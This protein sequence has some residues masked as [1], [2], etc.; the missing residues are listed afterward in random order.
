MDKIILGLLMLNRLTVY[1]IRG[2]I[3]KNFQAM[4]SDS[5][6]S[7]Q[8]AMKKLLSAQMVTCSEYIE[9]SVNKKR[10]SIS[11]K[12][13]KEFMHW[14]QIPAEISDSK[15]MELGKLL[16]MGL[17]P[18]RKRLP[19]IDEIIQKLETEL[20]GLLCLWDSVKSQSSAAKEQAID[21]WK[22]D[23]EYLE[24]IKDATQNPDIFGSADGIVN[25]EFCALQYGIDNF[26][27]N[28]E[29]FQTLKK[30]IQSGKGNFFQIKQRR[31]QKP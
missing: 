2:I 26:R 5:F 17:V 13:R 1:E 28:I 18:A 19:L 20:S 21:I 16:F 11:G 10:Y 8:A 29:W 9:K 15:N 24:G 31:G 25:F 3:R 6:G 12:G 7:I 27:F 14:L 22:K 4:C 23:A 30:N